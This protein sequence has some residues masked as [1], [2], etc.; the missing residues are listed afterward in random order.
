MPH[1]SSTSRRDT[2]EGGSIAR[3]KKTRQTV[4]HVED[5][6]PKKGLESHVDLEPTEMECHDKA[7]SWAITGAIESAGTQGSQL[8][9]NK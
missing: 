7:I 4:P 6:L 8:A 9:M 1:S 5:A 2:E 3:S